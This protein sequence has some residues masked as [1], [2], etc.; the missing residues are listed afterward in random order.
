MK[1]KVEYFT[2]KEF[3]CPCCSGGL[4]SAQLVYALD[5]LRMAWAAP[6][7]VNSGYRCEKHNREVG[8]VPPSRHLLGLAADIAPVDAAAIGPFQTLV[9]Y[10]FGRREGWELK[11]YQRFVHVAVPRGEEKHL[12]KGGLL[13]ITAA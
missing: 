9:G 12:W 11:F 2:P 6:I 3:I 13:T 4:I 5:I 10:I 8:G 1:Y 7:R